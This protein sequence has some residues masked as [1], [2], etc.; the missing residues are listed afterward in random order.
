[1][2]RLPNI[3]A[4]TDSEKIKQTADFLFQFVRELNLKMESIDESTEKK[5]E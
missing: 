5:K 3:N 2:F 1:M 4:S